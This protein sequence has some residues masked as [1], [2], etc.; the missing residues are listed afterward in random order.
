MKKTAKSLL[1]VLILLLNNSVFTQNIKIYVTPPIT[2]TKIIP[3]SVI[4]PAYLSNTIFIN[5]S[6]GEYEPAS[7]TI[8]TLDGIPDLV[9]EPT[10]LIG[11]DGNI[12]A[13]NIDIKVVKCWWQASAS[14]INTD[15]RFLIPELLLNDNSLVYID[16]T[17]NYLR[18]PSLLNLPPLPLPCGHIFFNLF[19]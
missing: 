19:S 15:G 3:T 13:E 2:E 9:I 6:P 12:P 7:F 17:Y 16:S 18:L 1:Y 14:T 10:S 8:K 11:A 5:A 4:S